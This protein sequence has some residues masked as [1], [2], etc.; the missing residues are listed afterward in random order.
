M[1]S[2][3]VAAAAAG[4]SCRPSGCKLS[5]PRR[6]PS[7]HPICSYRPIPATRRSPGL[8]CGILRW[9][10]AL[11]CAR[12]KRGIVFLADRAQGQ[13]LKYKGVPSCSGVAAGSGPGLRLTG[14]IFLHSINDAALQFTDRLVVFPQGH[15]AG[16]GIVG[17]RV[18]IHG[19]LESRIRCGPVSLLVIDLT[20]QKSSGP[21]CNIDRAVKH[22]LVD[23]DCYFRIAEAR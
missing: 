14:C 1:K 18:I 4:F 10:T 19:M 13:A 6:L 20:D 9:N 2:R 3:S 11:R 8:S 21:W 23:L 5:R 22:L 15:Q 7:G 17:R 16:V 12:M